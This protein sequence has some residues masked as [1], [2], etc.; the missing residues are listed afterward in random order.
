MERVGQVAHSTAPVLILGET[1]SG[2][3]VIARAIHTR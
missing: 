1:G 3:E 2:K